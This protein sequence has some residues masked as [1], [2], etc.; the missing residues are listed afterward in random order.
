MII[1]GDFCLE[2][3]MGIVSPWNSPNVEI[4]RELDWVES[5]FR[6]IMID[7]LQASSWE[8]ENM[9]FSICFTNQTIG[10]T[11]Q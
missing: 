2:L 1:L 8:K 7:Q 11:L 5:C 6:Q 9:I 10:I 4:I 3:S